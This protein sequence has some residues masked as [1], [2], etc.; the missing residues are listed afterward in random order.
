MAD[1]DRQIKNQQDKK[2]R[3]IG[4]SDARLHNSRKCWLTDE[5]TTIVGVYGPG[6]SMEISSNWSQPFSEMTP[7]NAAQT[8][9]GL[10]QATFGV[11]MVKT[12]NT[13]QVW[14]GNQPTQLNLELQLYA[15]RDPDI[16]VMQPLSALEEFIAPDVSWF[17]GIGQI[18]K[19][20]QLRIGT[21]AIYQPLVLNSVSIPFDKETDLK[22]RFVRCTVNLALSTA[23]VISKDLLKKGFC[24]IQSGYLTSKDK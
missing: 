9:G 21:M 3:I 7:G 11:T 10:L 2:T 24:G 4:N 14:Q 17:W 8:A 1:E 6:T 20:L 16:E 13:Q 23:T 22:G 12:L 18:A 19:A 15:L 5:T